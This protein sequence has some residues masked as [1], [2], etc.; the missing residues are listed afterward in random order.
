MRPKLSDTHLGGTGYKS[1]KPVPDTSPIEFDSIGVLLCG[2]LL[3][4][5]P[6]FL[7]SSFDDRLHVF[8]ATV[9]QF[10]AVDKYCGGSSHAYPD[11]LLVILPD[12]AVDSGIFLLFFKF[13]FIQ[14]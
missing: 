7:K 11:A 6:L 4:F 5:A 13:S 14:I 2:F 1:P 10:F 3:G 9:P 8:H 12:A